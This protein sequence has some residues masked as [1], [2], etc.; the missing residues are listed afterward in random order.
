VA[1]KKN[2]E[3]VF[4]TRGA[5]KAA[6][7]TKTVDSRLVSLGKTALKVGGALFAA[8]GVIR[9]LGAITTAAEKVSK[10]KVMTTA[11]QNMGKQLGF[12]AQSLEKLRK[13]TNNTMSD[14]ELLEL[15]NNALLL[16]IVKSDDEMAT[17]FDTAQRLAK[18][19]GK[20]TRYGVE[21]LVTGMGRQSRLMLDNIGIIVKADDAYKAMAKSIG[22]SVDGLTDAQKKQAFLTATMESAEKK[23]ATLGAEEETTADLTSE[24]KVAFEQLSLELG[25]RANPFV[26]Q[27]TR[28]LIKLTNASRDFIGEESWRDHLKN[29]APEL[30][31]ITL[32]VNQLNN[33]LGGAQGVA[34]WREA[35][36]SIDG[37]MARY[38][39]MARAVTQAAEEQEEFNN[40]FEMADDVVP[41]ELIKETV[42]QTKS[43]GYELA[44]V[45]AQLTEWGETGGEAANALAAQFAPAV[46]LTDRFTSNLAQAIIYGQDLGEAVVSSLQ[47]IAAELMAKAAT[48]AIMNMITGGQFGAAEGVTS[49][50]G[51][52]LKGF[53]GQTPT[54]NNNINIS[55]GLISDSYVRNTLVP[56]MNRVRS[57]G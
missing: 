2:I 51:Y 27:F 22:T 50:L 25:E 37:V 56:A 57:F 13:A 47:A 26:E 29:I 44:Q 40:L 34:A 6:Q 23:V 7:Q 43:Y 21:S 17:M 52:F 41:T 49:G 55:G 35:Q 20:D 53:S 36:D 28:G 9:G 11:F 14:M 5:E 54:V 30:F 10:I 33:A 16:G 46:A 31:G 19:L 18:A 32:H 12:N 48:F 24:L 1:V 45:N 38:L 15:A 8:K 4:K 3:L 39:E 42:E